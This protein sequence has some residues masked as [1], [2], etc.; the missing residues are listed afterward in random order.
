MNKIY[1][2]KLKKKKKPTEFLKE[3]VCLKQGGFYDTDRDQYI[4]GAARR[5]LITAE[6]Q[7]PHLVVRSTQTRVHRVFQGRLNRSHCCRLYP[8]VKR[9]P[10]S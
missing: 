7:S 9:K 10:S 5:T 1:T 2:L 8:L 4:L 3:T 6:V